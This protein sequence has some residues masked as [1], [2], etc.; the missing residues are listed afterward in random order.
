[1][2]VS[3]ALEYNYSCGDFHYIIDTASAMCTHFQATCGIAMEH[4]ARLQKRRQRERERDSQ[5]TWHEQARMHQQ[6]SRALE[7]SQQRSVNYDD[8]LHKARSS[9]ILSFYRLQVC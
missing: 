2:Y 9:S 1:M 6:M 7:T 4:L 8:T 5:E 3:H